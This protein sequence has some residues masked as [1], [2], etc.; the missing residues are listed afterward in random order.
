MMDMSY[1]ICQGITR[2]VLGLSLNLNLY[3]VVDFREVKE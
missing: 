3:L 2:D 1:G